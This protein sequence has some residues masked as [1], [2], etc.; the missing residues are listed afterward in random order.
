MDCLASYSPTLFKYATAKSTV[1]GQ[2]CTRC[3]K[4]SYLTM[5]STLWTCIWEKPLVSFATNCYLLKFSNSNVHTH[6]ALSSSFPT[7]VVLAAYQNLST[8]YT[9]TTI[10]RDKLSDF[11]NMYFEAPKTES[12]VPSDWKSRWND[13][14]FFR[15]LHFFSQKSE[16]LCCCCVCC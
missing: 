15:F 14:F 4:Q 16:Y 5:T 9:N 8:T 10:P 2:S 1:L 13:G 12:C 11:V 6:S 7:D 3:R